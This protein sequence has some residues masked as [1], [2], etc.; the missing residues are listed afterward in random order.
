M[1]L[2]GSYKDLLTK[3][4]VVGGRGSSYVPSVQAALRKSELE[5]DLS[6]LV[7]LCLFFYKPHV[8]EGEENPTNKPKQ[9]SG[10]ETR[11][12]GVLVEYRAG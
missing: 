3:V 4:D 10:S 1:V 2:N 8:S 11:L 5:C 7:S 12:G 6:F 9:L